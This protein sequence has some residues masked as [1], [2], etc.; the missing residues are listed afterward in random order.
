MPENPSLL[1]N[2][3]AARTESG[4]IVD[5]KTSLVTDQPEK[6]ETKAEPDATKTADPEPKPAEKSEDD[7]SLLNK[8]DEK[9]AGAPEKYEPFKVP[10]GFTL[11]EAVATEAGTL[12]KEMGLNQDQAQKLVDFHAAKTTEAAQAPFKLWQDMNAKWTKE[13]VSDSALGDG[14][15]LRTEVKSAIAKTID[16]LGPTLAPAFREAMDLTGAGNHPAFVKA[17][18]ELSK[19]ATE[20]SHV[21]AGGPTKFGTARPGDRPESAAAAMYPSLPSGR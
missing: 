8:K 1:A 10:E 5:Q 9:A 6:T 4:E 14:K 16:S 12:F 3:P 15:G 19:L 17:M 7:K 20:G 2:D 21:K 13:T 18:Y 11:D